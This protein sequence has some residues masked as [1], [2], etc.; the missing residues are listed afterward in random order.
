VEGGG[1]EQGSVP[2]AAARQGLGARRE[3]RGRGDEHVCF[4]CGGFTLA[5][6]GAFRCIDLLFLRFSYLFTKGRLMDAEIIGEFLEISPL[7]SRNSPI[8]SRC[9]FQHLEFLNLMAAFHWSESRFGVL[10]F[11]EGKCWLGQG[12]GKSAESS[13]SANIKGS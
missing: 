7:I 6:S 5:G 9:L 10:S 12:I 13:L 3:G 8:I 11:L 2:A 1:D 4:L